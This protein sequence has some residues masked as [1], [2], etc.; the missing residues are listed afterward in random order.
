MANIIE[1]WIGILF[2]LHD[3]NQYQ[4]KNDNKRDRKLGLNPQ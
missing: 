4:M 2:A 1:A 3:F